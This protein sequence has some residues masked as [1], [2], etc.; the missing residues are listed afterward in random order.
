MIDGRL[1]WARPVCISCTKI[2]APWACT[3]SELMLIQRPDL[4]LTWLRMT[5]TD[6][7]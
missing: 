4:I 1:V 6:S 5:L 3:A 2:L 7:E